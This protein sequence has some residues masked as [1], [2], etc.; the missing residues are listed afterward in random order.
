MDTRDSESA[1]LTNSHA[2]DGKLDP[3]NKVESN[4]VGKKPLGRKLSMS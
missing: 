1:P 2:A 3:I 4:I